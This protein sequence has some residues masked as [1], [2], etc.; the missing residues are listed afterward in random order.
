MSELQILTFPTGDEVSLL[1]ITSDT[2]E[3]GAI[4]ACFTGIC[5]EPPLCLSRV[6]PSYLSDN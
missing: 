5:T 2:G 3:T 1:G 4:A 6:S